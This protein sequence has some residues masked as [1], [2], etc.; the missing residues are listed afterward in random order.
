MQ[1]CFYMVQAG[2]W[3]QKGAPK[4]PEAKTSKLTCAP[5]SDR[6]EEYMKTRKCV[7]VFGFVSLCVCVS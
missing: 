3:Q 4:L 1:S 5:E 2:A 7:T 6:D